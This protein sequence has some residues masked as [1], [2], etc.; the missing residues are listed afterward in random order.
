MAET[1]AEIIMGES[2]EG[3]RIRE[4]LAPTAADMGFE[5]VRIRRMG[6]EGR[7][8]L[9]IMAERT[10]GTMDIGGCTDLSHAFSAI[11][12]VEDPISGA[13]DL[14]VSSPGVDRPLTRLKDFDRFQ[15]FEAKL[16]TRGLIDGR[17]RF[18]GEIE[19]TDGG[20]VLLRVELNPGEDSQVL[21]FAPDMVADAKIIITDD[22]FRELSKQKQA[23]LKDAGPSMDE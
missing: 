20:E 15:G 7:S 1:G 4:L 9:Q 2:A 13:Y 3:A 10:D 6:S 14:E 5:I 19:G 12:D 17:K 16:E 23:E 18:R 11:L 21:G 22:M 8:T